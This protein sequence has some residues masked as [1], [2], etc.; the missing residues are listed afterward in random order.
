M[1]RLENVLKISLQGVLK[2]S[3]RRIEDVFRMYW[4]LLEDVLKTFL[5]DVLQTSWQGVLKIS[6]RRLEDIFETSW[7][8]L[9]DVLKT[10]WQDVLKTSWRCMAKAKILF[11]TKTSLWRLKDVFLRRRRKTSSIRLHQDMLAGVLSIRE[12]HCYFISQLQTHFMD[13]L[14]LLLLI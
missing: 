2:I 8:R 1:I 4:R 11:L 3:W 5:Q 9:E 7:R 14:R 6:W 10:F 13:F 12:K